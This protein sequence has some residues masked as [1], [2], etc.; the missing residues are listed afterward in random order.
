[1]TTMLELARDVQGYPVFAPQACKDIYSA[2]LA[3][4]T[5]SS[6]TVPSN[7]PLWIA[8]ITPQPATDIWCDLSGATA[9]AQ[10][11]GTLVAGTA[12]LIPTGYMYARTVAAGS[13]ISLIT[14]TTTAEVSISLYAIGYPH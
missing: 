5:A 8:I 9:V 7:Y 6:I 1:M 4:G 2:K 14:D 12:E 3:T 10:T 13:N 11:S